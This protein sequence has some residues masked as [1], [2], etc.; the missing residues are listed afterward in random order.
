MRLQFEILVSNILKE[1]DEN[2]IDLLK[3]LPELK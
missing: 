2:K 1:N 3:Q